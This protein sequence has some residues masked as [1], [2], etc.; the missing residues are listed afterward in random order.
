[1][2][3]K[4]RSR[5]K[6]I[7]LMRCRSSQYSKHTHRSSHFTMVGLWGSQGV[8]NRQALA[9]TGL[10]TMS[11]LVSKFPEL[12]W[13]GSLGMSQAR[14]LASMPYIAELL[15]LSKIDCKLLTLFV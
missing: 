3:T 13:T 10:I 1:M 7:H 8:H 4:K 14:L 15:H 12:S 6:R 2:S 9:G 5:S 11:R